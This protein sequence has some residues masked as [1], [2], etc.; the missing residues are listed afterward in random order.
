[1]NKIKAIIIDDKNMN[2]EMLQQLL[3][4]FCPS[5]QVVATATDIA[6][7]YATINEHQPDLVF[8]DIELNKGTGFDL[9]HMFHPV[10]FKTVFTTAYDQYA[11]EAFREHAVDYLLK[12]IN[13]RHLQEAIA[14]VQASLPQQAIKM[15]V[16]E[17]PLPKTKISL[18]TLEGFLFIDYNDILRCEA[19]GSYSNFHLSDGRKIMVSMRLK[20]CETLLPEQVF[21][22]V[23]H[24]H[25]INVNHVV[26]YIRGR[27]GQVVLTGNVVVEVASSKKEQ[28][29]QSLKKMW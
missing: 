22:R 24:S 28:F 19:S 26:K 8:L 20:E 23:H 15:P 4:Q 9:L 12:P 10:F 6:T 21:Y 2:I 7:G 1:M 16:Y 27:V 29:L 11:L 17:V 14:K 5:I 18:P 13:L 3:E 25:I